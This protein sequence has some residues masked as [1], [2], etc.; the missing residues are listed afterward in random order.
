MHNDDL[1]EHGAFVLG[2]VPLQ[3]VPQPAHDAVGVVEASVVL[4]VAP[5]VP[6]VQGNVIPAD[7]S[8]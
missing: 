2:E 7:Q 1:E 4:R 6:Q 5:Q 8:L 3:H